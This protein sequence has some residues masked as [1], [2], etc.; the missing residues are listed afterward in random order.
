MNYR[1]A[2]IEGDGIGPEVTRAALAVLDR[3]AAAHG[4]RLTYR[5]VLAGGAAIDATGEPLPAETVRVCRASDAVLLGAVGG[6]KWDTLPGDRRPERA[7]LGLREQLGLYANLRPALLH[8]ALRDTCPL[9]ADIAARGMDMLIVRE[10]VGGIYFGERGRRAT[11]RGEAAFDTECYTAAEVRRIG[12]VAFELAMRR[13]RQLTS[14]DKANVLESSRLWRE[15]MVSLSAEYPAVTLRHLYVD[16]A[17]MQLVRAPADFD[18][19]VCSNLFGDIL[20]DEASAV[21]G[22]IGLSPSASL[23]EGRFGLYEPIH[24]SAPDIAG[25]GL[26]NPL[27]AILS[28]ALLL[29]HSLG[30]HEAAGAVEQAVA[31]ALA[32]GA[33]TRD[34]AGGAGQPF[35]STEQM[36]E[37]VL[38]H[39]P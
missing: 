23:G 39:C 7:I 5:H 31:R 30:L 24:G 34:L 35:V 27:A 6:P 12:R 29:R 3:V 17:A 32:E 20:S 13:R 9:R 22:S 8:P 28:A 21:T 37:A 2:V 18:V 1:I 14:V 10:L 19:L 26:A 4:H 36:T 33:R 16:N 25:Q 15:V 11:D 38:R